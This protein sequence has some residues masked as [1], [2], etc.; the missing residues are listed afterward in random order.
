MN[1]L[2]DGLDSGTSPSYPP[3][4]I[5]KTDDDHYVI[6]VAVAGFSQDEITITEHDGQLEITG[7]KAAS[8]ENQPSF[9]HRGISSRKFNRS[10]NLADYVVVKSADMENGILTIG[11]ERLV[12]EEMKPK[13]IAINYKS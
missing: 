7:T 5:I 12:P 13:T 3:Y 8:D 1:H 4:N 6:E 10:F 9:L 11:L 2:L